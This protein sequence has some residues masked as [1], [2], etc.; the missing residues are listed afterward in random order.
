MDKVGENSKDFFIYREPL[1][2]YTKISFSIHFFL[3]LSI[4]FFPKNL[5]IFK[6][7]GPITTVVPAIR[8]DVVGMPKMTLQELKKI[9]SGEGGGIDKE[10]VQSDSIDFKKKGRNLSDLLK[11]EAQKDLSLRPDVQPNGKKG[12]GKF[13]GDLSKLVLEGNKISK[14]MA[15]IGDTRAMVMGVFGQYVSSIPDYV[16]PNWRLPASLLNLNLNCRVRIYLNAQG[17]LEKAELF[18]S[19]GNQEYDRRAIQAVMGS[20]FPKPDKEIVEKIKSGDIL[21]GFP[22]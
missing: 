10:D 4:I 11:S 22:L 3:I 12:K 13:K 1:G 14:G 2:T 8:V 6:S 20:S 18:E 16:R 21:L 7:T 17:K 5:N 9:T 19:S 15:L